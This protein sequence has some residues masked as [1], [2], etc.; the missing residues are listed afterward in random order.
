MVST[1]QA[2]TGQVI[3]KVWNDEAFKERLLANPKAA[4]RDEFGIEIPDSTEVKALTQTESKM[5]LVIPPNP[6]ELKVKKPNEYPMW[7]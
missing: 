6:T 2:I 1:E 4:I 3:T 5:Y 7:P